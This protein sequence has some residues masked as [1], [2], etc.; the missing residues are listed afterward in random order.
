MSKSSKAV[1]PVASKASA[2]SSALSVM[3]EGVSNMEL[4][5]VVAIVV[6]KAETQI[7][8]D[9]RGAKERY[10]VV[11]EGLKKAQEALVKA[12]EGVFVSGVVGERVTALRVALVAL[13]P[14]KV[15]VVVSS[16]DDKSVQG[17]LRVFSDS[18]ATWVQ[19]QFP[20]SAPLPVGWDKLLADVEGGRKLV[21]EVQVEIGKLKGK[22]NNIP[23]LERRARAKIAERSL[24]ATAKGKALISL[25]TDGLDEEIKALAE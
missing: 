25:I 6:S 4:G 19:C 16:F 22:L 5:D 8:A 14:G 3:P 11:S 15:D 13:Y 21:S 2:L 9:L 20:V 23:Q 7:N 12:Q 1:V 17:S 24:G 18:N 10:K